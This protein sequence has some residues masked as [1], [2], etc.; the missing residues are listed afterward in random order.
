MLSGCLVVLLP[1]V[2]V[3]WVGDGVMWLG[4]RLG[5]GLRMGTGWGMGFGMGLRIEMKID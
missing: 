3:G 1:V 5:T 4:M 2:F